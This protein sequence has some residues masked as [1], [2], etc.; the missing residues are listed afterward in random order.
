MKTKY[1]TIGTIGVALGYSVLVYV[2]NCEKIWD[3]FNTFVGSTVSFFFAVLGGMYLLKVQSDALKES[4]HKELGMLLG[5]EF[6]DL[7]R[8]L[9][10]K[11]RLPL[12]MQGGSTYHVL[13]AFVQPLVIEKAALSGVFLQSESENL[14]HLARKIRMFSFQLE[15]LMGLISG[16][17]SEQFINHATRNIEETRVAAIVGL[18]QVAKQL[19]LSINESYLD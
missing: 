2:F 13:V 7:I 14:L 17:S 6:S 9:S 1:F 10:D 16:Q 8:I 18:R 4:Q 15:Y 12:C 19:G 5:A 11:D 3:W